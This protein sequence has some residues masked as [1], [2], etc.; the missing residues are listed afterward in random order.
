MTKFLKQ[1]L[2]HIRFPLLPTADTTRP[3]H[4][5]P[6]FKAYFAVLSKVKVQQPTRL[7]NCYNSPPLDIVLSQFS[8]TRPTYFLTIT[9]KYFVRSSYFLIS[10]Y[11]T[12][13]LAALYKIC[14]LYCSHKVRQHD[15]Q[16]YKLIISSTH[17]S[18]STCV[19][20]CKTQFRYLTY[21]TLN[22]KQEI[23]RISHVLRDLSCWSL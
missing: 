19:R 3:C 15:T 11:A 23:F 20:Q 1:Y 16:T 13:T 8:L 14:D 18:T 2:S 6:T 4:A 21:R 5:V 7:Q 12:P 22:T 17:N 10:A 9:T